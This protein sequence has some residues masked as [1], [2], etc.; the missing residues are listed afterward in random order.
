MTSRPLVQRVEIDAARAQQQISALERQL[1]ALERPINIPVDIQSDQGLDQ[2]QRDIAQVDNQRVDVEVDVAGVDQADASFADLNRELEQTDNELR[3]VAA[4]ADRTGRDLDNAAEKGVRGFKGLALGAGAFGAALIAVQGI[5]ALVRGA[6]AAIE[7]AS[8]F[9]ESISKANVVFGDFSGDIED[10]ARTGPEALGLSTAAALEATATFGNLFVALG[11]T[12]DAAAVLA[13]DIVQLASDLA[14]FNNIEVAEAVEKLRAGLVGEA[15]PLRTL[16]VNINAVLVEAKALELGLVDAN[17]AVTE[18]G[19]VQAR[20]ALI[21][22]QTTTAQGD[23]ART[24]DGIANTQRTLRAEFADVSASIGQA[25]LPAYQALLDLAPAVL[26]ALEDLT[27]V[28]GALASQ[29]AEAVPSVSAF[30]DAIQ[31]LGE[32]PGAIGNLAG[33]GQGLFDIFTSIV[34]GMGDVEGGIARIGAEIDDLNVSKLRTSLVDALQAGVDPATALANTLVALSDTGLDPTQIQAF[35]ESFTGIADIDL[36]R[37]QDVAAAIRAQ[38]EAAGVE[39]VEIEALIR[40]I[41]GLVSAGQTARAQARGTGGRRESADNVRA[42]EEAAAAARVAAEATMTEV[43]ALEILGTEADRTGLSIG[44]MLI[45]LEDLPPELQLVAKTVD[46]STAAFLR[47]MA[48]ID[49]LQEPIGALPGTL[50]ET[51][52]ALQDTEG[53]IVTDFDT[54]LNQLEANLEAR[55]AFETNLAI[56]RA[57]GLDDL[58]NVFDEAGVPSAQALA[59]AVAS[60]EKL[61]E[62]KAL[63]EGDFGTAAE[64]LMGILSAGMES[65]DLTRQ[66]LVDNLI[67]AAT[68]ADDPAVRA[69]LTA[70]AES[71]ALEIPVRFGPIPNAPAEAR[72][73]NPAAPAPGQGAP[74]DA[75]RSDQQGVV[76]QNF[77][78]EPVPTSQTQQAAQ[79]AAAILG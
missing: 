19:K 54:F 38:G 76:V 23:Y 47:Q 66:A 73:S 63:L 56:L 57:L 6:G 26:T 10:F 33:L 58:A 41:F 4:E 8:D 44:S 7:A 27:P 12:Q 68:L 14:S 69:A 64:D 42:A 16:G 18:A 30:A 67:Q 65:S 32:I 29:A 55:Q 70:L 25:L 35:A 17:G 79:Q 71:L 37:M 13:P 22:E 48:G 61:A 46:E 28:I 62:A 21:L 72:V 3:E 15:E 50:E 75:R 59:D 52:A 49:A 11:L 78:T 2:L 53:Q 51:A 9:E 20:Y 40:G 45:N 39:A 60:P 36:G 74:E 5:G 43:E 34:P 31:A 24:A 1:A 77:Y